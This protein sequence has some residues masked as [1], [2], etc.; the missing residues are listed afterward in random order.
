MSPGRPA[1]SHPAHEATI[2]EI[3]AIRRR[4]LGD[5]EISSKAR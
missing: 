2:D 4:N 5:D 3:S 1:R